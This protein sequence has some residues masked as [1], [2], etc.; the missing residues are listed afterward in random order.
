MRTSLHCVMKSYEKLCEM[1][2]A[3]PKLTPE[4]EVEV[5]EFQ[6]RGCIY[7]RTTN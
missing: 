2:K 1:E 6:E 7:E 3:L 4:E 5:A